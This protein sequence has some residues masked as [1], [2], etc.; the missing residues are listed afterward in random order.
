MSAGIVGAVEVG[1]EWDASGHVVG[2][3]SEGRGDEF[4]QIGNHNNADAAWEGWGG[5]ECDIEGG[6]GRAG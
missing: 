3:R 6:T 5:G 1:G 2:A 4:I